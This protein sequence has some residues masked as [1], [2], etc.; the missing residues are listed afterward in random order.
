M[1]RLVRAALLA[2]VSAFPSSARADGR[3]VVGWEPTERA[4]ATSATTPDQ[5]ALIVWDE[6][7]E[8]LVV[9]TAFTGKGRDFAWIVPLPSVPKIEASTTGL[10]PTLDSL[11]GPEVVH[12][13]PPYW[14]FV[15]LFG[16]GGWLIAR[17]RESP[18]ILG[19]LSAIAGCVVLAYLTVG[20]PVTPSRHSKGV[21]T[22]GD[23]GASASVEKP[24]VVVHERRVVGT[25]E[26]ATIS[27]RDPSALLDWLK[28]NGY[29]AQPE[30]APVVA[31]HVAEGWVFVAAKI[32]REDDDSA[33]PVR[34]HPLA[35][36]FATGKPVYPMRLTGPDNG[37]CRVELFVAAERRAKGDGF[38]LDCCDGLG[39]SRYATGIFWRRCPEGELKRL[40]GGD[41]TLT[42]LSRTFDE[43]AMSRD[44]EIGWDAP[45]EFRRTRYSN[46]GAAVT[47]ANFAG[48]AA[49]FVGAFFWSLD[50]GRR[51]GERTAP[52]SAWR[53]W[54]WAWVAALA[55]VGT[56]LALPRV[57]VRVVG[58]RQVGERFTLPASI[59]GKPPTMESARAWA[60]DAARGIT[61]QH[62]GGDVREEDSPGNYVIREI[63]G[64]PFL[65]WMNDDGVEIAATDG[66]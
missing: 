43:A 56:W 15:A 62:L 59:D 18:H 54:S 36:T 60:A 9:E 12:E 63:R 19:V 26:T 27:S 44:V 16:A 20:I 46:Y 3:V 45:R 22:L 29:A 21:L 53:R 10:F 33:T 61:N 28:T 40:V 5:R 65:S 25:F 55:F 58:E 7:K 34:I 14:I 48:F 52:N 24:A 30:I 57:A 51:R 4:V 35:F 11:T 50:V 6:G 23:G 1:K 8:T 37:D 38:D 2:A 41:R 13:V 64:R 31:Q 17:R 39:V 49:L 47:A 42:R 66:W 32:R